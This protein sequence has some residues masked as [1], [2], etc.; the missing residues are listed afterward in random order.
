MGDFVFFEELFHLLGD[1]VAIVWDR[2]ERDL[3]AGFRLLRLLG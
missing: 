3:L 2:D 1:H